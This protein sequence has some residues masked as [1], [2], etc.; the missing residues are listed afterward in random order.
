[1]KM[2]VQAA[3]CGGGDYEP[4]H[5]LKNKLHINFSRKL[6]CYEVSYQLV[7]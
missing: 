5:S 2:H 1:M 3:G 7:D 4:T 6:L